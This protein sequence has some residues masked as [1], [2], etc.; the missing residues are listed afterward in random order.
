MTVSY[1]NTYLQ[2]NVRIPFAIFVLFFMLDIKML[3]R[4]F[5]VMIFL[6]EMALIEKMKSRKNIS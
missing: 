6:C 1:V 2:I 5:T 3:L 4:L